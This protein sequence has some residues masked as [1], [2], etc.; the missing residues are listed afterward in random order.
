MAEYRIKISYST[1]NSFGSEDTT[2]YLELTWENLDIAKENLQSIKEHYEMYR[3][4]EGWG[5]KLTKEQWFAKNIDKSWF[6]NEQ[7]LYSIKPNRHIQENDKVKVG[8][9]NWE[10]R[11]DVFIAQHCINLKADNG[12]NMQILA[13]WCGY[14][15]TLYSAEIEV[16][17]DG[18]KI[19]F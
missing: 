6:V 19:S 4:I 11:S 17:N 13:F 12:N 8:D 10:Y 16:N 2:D 3:N 1:G 15:E 5:S 14:F 9:G 18:M 7:K